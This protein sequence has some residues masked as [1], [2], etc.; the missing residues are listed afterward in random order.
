MSAESATGLAMSARQREQFF[1]EGYVMVPALFAPDDLEPMRREIAE[2]IDAE[3]Q[4][5]FAA[6]AISD[7]FASEKF[8]TRLTRLVAAYPEQTSI[9]MRAIEGK[10]GGGHTG[11]AIFD[12]LTHPRL[13]DAMEALVG[14][15]IVASSVYRIRPKVPGLGRGVVPWHQDSGYFSPSCDAKPDRDLLDSACGRDAGKR[16]LAGSAEHASAGRCD[17]PYGRQRRFS[18]NRRRRFAWP[19]EPVRHGSRAIG[20]RVVADKPD[21]ALLPAQRHRRDPMEP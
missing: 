20:R 14:P 15:E 6:G 8:E 13:L 3:A 17:A 18:R 12:L 10:A 9:F 19:A 16:L 5:L 11:T 21:A 7:T 2:V 4:R 1:A